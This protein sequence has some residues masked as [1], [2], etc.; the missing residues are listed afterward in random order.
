MPEMTRSLA[1]TKSVYS[2]IRVPWQINGFQN[3]WWVKLP[4]G[5][6]KLD[7]EVIL[8]KGGGGGGGGGS[9]QLWI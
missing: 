5:A 2:Q 6:F 7:I 1:T 3:V 8:G 4:G 9:R